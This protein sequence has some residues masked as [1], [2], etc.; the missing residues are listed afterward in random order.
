MYQ[1]L[2]GLLESDRTHHFVTELCWFAVVADECD[3]YV[4]ALLPVLNLL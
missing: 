2:A 4:A 1:L 3:E